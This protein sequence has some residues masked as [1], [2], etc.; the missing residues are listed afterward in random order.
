MAGREKTNFPEPQKN[1]NFI[2]CGTVHQEGETYLCA[3]R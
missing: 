2:H 1:R 3:N